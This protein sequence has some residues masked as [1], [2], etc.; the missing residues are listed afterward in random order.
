MS[1]SKSGALLG[2]AART[3]A[4]ELREG[5]RK[6]DSTFSKAQQIVDT[7][8]DMYGEEGNEVYQAWL[9]TTPDDDAGFDLA[10][11]DKLAELENLDITAWLDPRSD[12]EKGLD[13]DGADLRA[14]QRTAQ[15]QLWDFTPLPSNMPDINFDTVDEIP[16]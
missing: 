14:T 15:E 2:A 5:L 7:L 11:D 4:R 3:E 1:R 9:D 16:F 6:T 12:A 10:C 13:E 8:V